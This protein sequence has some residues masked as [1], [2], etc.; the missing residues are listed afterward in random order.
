MKNLSL[1]ITISVL[2]FNP[3]QDGGDGGDGRGGGG[4]LQKGPPNSFTVFG[5]NF[6]FP[7]NLFVILM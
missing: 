4:V 3:I 1:R 5:F 2:I 7:V 6:L